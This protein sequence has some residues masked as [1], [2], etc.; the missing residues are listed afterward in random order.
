MTQI[1]WLTVDAA[2]IGLAANAQPQRRH[3][4]QEPDF[5]VFRSPDT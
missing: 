1:G 5:V 4:A 2:F 3:P